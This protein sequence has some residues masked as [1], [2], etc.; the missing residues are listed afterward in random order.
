VPSLERSNLW[1][2]K[3]KKQQKVVSIKKHFNR[4]RLKYFPSKDTRSSFSCSWKTVGELCCLKFVNQRRTFW[5]FYSRR[6]L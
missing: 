5:D 3:P 1:S 6:F 2:K 4:F